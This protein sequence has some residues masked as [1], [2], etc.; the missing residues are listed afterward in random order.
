MML[1]L[2]TMPFRFGLATM[3]AGSNVRRALVGSELPETEA[4][5]RIYARNLEVPAGGGVGTARALACAYGEFASGGRKLGVREETLRELMAPPVPPAC[6]FRDE[7]FKLESRFSLGFTKPGPQH[8]FGH[9]GSFG[10]PGTGG[11]FGFADP[12]NQLGFGYVP[13]RMIMRLID[14]RG[15]ALRQATYA[16]I[17]LTDPYGEN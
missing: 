2:F 9:A 13:N 16:S 8:R 7:C 12:P 4:K 14:P 17:G 10:A 15:E 11:S 1:V 3:H 5:G 6:G